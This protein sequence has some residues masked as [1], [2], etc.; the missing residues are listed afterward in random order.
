MVMSLL[1][2][3][4]F[5]V[6]RLTFQDR[7]FALFAC[8]TLTLGLWA[9]TLIFGVANGLLLRPLPYRDGDQLVA[10]TASHVKSQRLNLGLSQLAF[11]N[12]ASLPGVDAAAAYQ[13]RGM[14]VTIG[15]EPQRLS[16]AATMPRLF[17]VL[18]VTPVAGRI[19]SPDELRR[20]E[21]VVVISELL[22]QRANWSSTDAI[23]RTLTIDGR[24][25]TVVGVLPRRVR[26]PEIAQIWVPLV[27]AP[28]TAGA[29]GSLSVIARITSDSVV[30]QEQLRSVAYTIAQAGPEP[31]WTL[32][33][34]SLN[35]LQ[36]EG[37][38]PLVLTAVFGS[39]LLLFVVSA[40]VAALMLARG[41]A[42]QAEFGVMV[43]L[44][45]S[46]R[47]II[48]QLLLES[49]VIAAVAS[50]CALLLTAWTLDYVPSALPVTE[51]P[52]WIQFGVDGRV[53]AFTLIAGVLGTFATGL[54]PA[55]Q[56]T[57]GDIASVIRS[58][59][60]TVAGG[61][62]TVLQRC[63]VGLQLLVATV[64]LI[65]GGLLVRSYLALANADLGYDTAG[66]YMLETELPQTRYAETGNV[67]SFYAALVE[68]LQASRDVTTAAVAGGTL[69]GRGGT[70]G[71]G[72]F[73]DI[74]LLGG[75]SSARRARV[76]Q[77]VVSNGFFDVLGVPLKR[78]RGFQIN[79][80]DNV[81]IVTEAFARWHFASISPLEQT[82]TVRAGG[83]DRPVRI[84]GVVGD[85]RDAFV[86]EAADAAA[87]PR[88]YLPLR[89][90][91]SR[92]ATVYVRSSAAP[93]ADIAVT[94]RD[95]VHAVDPNQPVWAATSLTDFVATTRSPV[96]WFGYL[97]GASAVI[98]LI[99]ACVGL[100][101]V[102]SYGVRRRERE[103]A[104]RTTFGAR[105]S[106]VM[107]MVLRDA[108][109]PGFIGLA[110]GIGGGTALGRS[111]GALLYGVP[112]FDI[113]V[114]SVTVMLLLSAVLAATL[115]PASRIF[116]AEPAALLRRD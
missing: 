102:V 58:G 8:G 53:V 95:A 83:V 65:G 37:L 49:A 27:L 3:L 79:E 44:G 32:Q 13:L 2:D 107:G 97:F 89:F 50:G 108:L 23:G 30:L 41:V 105:P 112:A 35:P 40:N 113:T 115:L 92:G 74:Q 42:R 55:L 47:R 21:P 29:A 15:S 110:F 10:I 20:D 24:N 86:G 104:I 59:S 106:Q 38:A 62:A 1:T 91:I 87:R 5:I 25:H 54:I 36:S 26:F 52:E 60:R 18:D 81:A 88:V 64:L 85:M 96:K 70:Q 48:V 66:V 75:I 93:A 71:T 114:T 4:R 11:E 101:G 61:S 34:R 116:R 19:F 14:N 76:E 100:Y 84:V 72:S 7:Q 39:A 80:A 90:G 31:G 67:V 63:L 68:R 57:K 82:I 77:V 16:G 22:V 6:R 12:V 109:R 51:L 9:A 78:G 103:F 33:T 73:D 94:I 46:R 69:A 111:L 56:S 98:A 28:A 17:A 43:A 45:A 99:V